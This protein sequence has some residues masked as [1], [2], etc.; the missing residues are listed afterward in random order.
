VNA[1]PYRRCSSR[2]VSRRAIPKPTPWTGLGS[3]GPGGRWGGALVLG[4]M[5]VASG[6]SR[7]VRHAV[8]G[9][10]GLGC[11]AGPASL[12]SGIAVMTG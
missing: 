6:G 2:R 7:P 3:R 12:R 8:H 4:G 10:L 11:G 5:S 9:I 1:V